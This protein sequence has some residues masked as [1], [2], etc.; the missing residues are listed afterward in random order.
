MVTLQVDGGV[1]PVSWTWLTPHEAREVG[2]ALLGA[3]GCVDTDALEER[4]ARAADRLEQ[5]ADDLEAEI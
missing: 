1:G 5:I 2:S 4:R 3:A